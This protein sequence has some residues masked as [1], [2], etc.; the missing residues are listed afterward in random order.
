MTVFCP[1]CA[2]PLPSAPPSTC[3]SCGYAVYLNAKPTASI[4]LLD[5]DRFLAL[6]RVREP[7][8]GGWDLPGGFCEG[9]EHPADAAVR[10]AREE[11]DVGVRLDRVIGMLLGA[12][13]A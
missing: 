13:R 10:E 11:M 6:L 5:S 8:A 7:A 12:Y 1:R 2:T 9:W 4:V 3:T